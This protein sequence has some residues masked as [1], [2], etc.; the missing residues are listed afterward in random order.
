MTDI[1]ESPPIDLPD[2]VARVAEAVVGLG[3]RRRGAAS[4]VLWAPGRVVTTACTLGGVSR[5][6]VVPA[7]GEPR[8]GEVRGVDPGTDLAVIAVEV[9]A[10]P[11]ADRR[12]A[13][14]VRVGDAVFAAGRDASGG[15]HASFGHLGAVGGAWRTWRGASVERWVRLDGGLYPGL[16]GAAVA[17]A[18]GRTIGIASPA[19]S[20]HHGVVLPAASVDRVVEALWTR[21]RIVRGWLGVAVQPVARSAVAPDA[22]Q[23]GALLVTGLGD[24]S[25]AASA[26][27]RVGDAIVAA[28]E[29]PVADLRAL[30]D[31]LEGLEAGAPVRLSLLRG[32]VPLS[33]DVAV[34]ERPSA[35]RC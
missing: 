32:G 13:A 4:G 19:L 25:P 22:G 8:V 16:A 28:G 1:P 24:G 7:D 30:R 35:S 26:G 11:V 34:G 20:R 14:T 17:D 21:G 15:V 27:L 3:L 33:V 10:A 31:A 2:A 18:T 23:G 6:Q 29:R 5:V 12:D 9:D